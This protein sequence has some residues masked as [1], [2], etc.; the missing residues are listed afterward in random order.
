MLKISPQIPRLYGKGLWGSW[1]KQ[2]SFQSGSREV[3]AWEADKDLELRISNAYCSPVGTAE[4]VE[5][6]IEHGLDGVIISHHGGRQLDSVPATLDALKECAP[7]AKGRIPLAIDSGIRRGTDIFKAL[8]LGADFAFRENSHLGSCGKIHPVYL[9]WH[10][11]NITWGTICDN[12][13][14]SVER[15]WGRWAVN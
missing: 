15:D 12:F 5:L 14:P 6:A 9:I 4:H 8:A 1:E 11:I 2:P 10:S 13:E 7:V 3:S